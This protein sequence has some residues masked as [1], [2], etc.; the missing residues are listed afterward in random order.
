VR[1]NIAGDLNL[2]HAN[3]VLDIYNINLFGGVTVN[4]IDTLNNPPLNQADAININSIGG[5][6]NVVTNASEMDGD[7]QVTG[8]TNLV[9]GGEGGNAYAVNNGLINASTF[10]GSLNFTAGAG[11]QTFIS[12]LFNDVFRGG[13]GA[14]LIDLSSGGS[15]SADAVVFSEFIAGAAQNPI[16]A[17]V[18]LV[19]GWSDNDQIRVDLSD[20][21][22]PT[23]NGN[24][25]QVAPGGAV[26]LNFGANQVSDIGGGPGPFVNLIHFDTLV[27]GGNL[28]QMFDQ[29]IGSGH[30]DVTATVDFITASMY[31]VASGRAIIFQVSSGA[32]AANVLD[33]TDGAS[34]GVVGTIQMSQADYAAFGVGN[35]VFVA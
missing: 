4:S 10:T 1:D 21:G 23:E 9:I 17:A 19:V 11:V 22:F 18:D 25:V 27:N 15:A 35:L 14:D 31:D 20:V 2:S 32:G 12:G 33:A 30:I 16:T 13:A 34:I 5:G 6:T 24:A 26:V 3:L 7:I 28:G 29:A 8:N